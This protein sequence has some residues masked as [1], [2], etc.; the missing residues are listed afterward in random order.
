M[1]PIWLP[2]FWQ[3][4]DRSLIPIRAQ[5]PWPLAEEQRLMGHVRFPPQVLCLQQHKTDSIGPVSELMQ[6]S[7]CQSTQV[8]LEYK[9]RP[10]V[11]KSLT[12]LKGINEDSQQKHCVHWR[13]ARSGLLCCSLMLCQQPFPKTKLELHFPFSFFP[14]NLLILLTSSCVYIN[15]I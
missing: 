8:S 7:F 2:C 5:E 4:S 13:T 6:V 15:V 3:C 10:W 12:D 14:V 11:W 1:V 9:D